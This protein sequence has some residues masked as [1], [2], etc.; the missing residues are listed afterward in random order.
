MMVS[1]GGTCAESGWSHP[2]KELVSFSTLITSLVG[3]TVE[4]VQ[5]V[6]SDEGVKL[7]FSNGCI[8][9]VG[10]SSMYGD[11]TLNGEHVEVEGR[12]RD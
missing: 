2:K 1:R 11:A 7:V 12:P 6:D 9:D 3:A 8:L 4:D 5:R 10:Y